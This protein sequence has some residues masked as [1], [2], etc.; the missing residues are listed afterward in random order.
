MH[1]TG[2]SLHY[3]EQSSKELVREELEKEI[4]KEVQVVDTMGEARRARLRQQD[5]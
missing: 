2:A 5:T 3:P 4:E 1:V